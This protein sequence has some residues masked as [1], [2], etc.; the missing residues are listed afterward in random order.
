M[1]NT[2]APQ[3]PQPGQYRPEGN[4]RAFNSDFR[5]GHLN[6]SPEEIRTELTTERQAL[7]LLGQVTDVNADGN[8]RIATTRGDVDVQL[9]SDD[10]SGQRVQVGE[11]V[12]IDIQPTQGREAPQVTIRPAP[13]E[14]QVTRVSETPVQ[15]EVRDAQTAQQ[16]AQSPNTQI[17]RPEQIDSSAA[18]PPN[19]FPEVGSLV[20]LDPVSPEQLEQLVQTRQLAVIETVSNALRPL[21]ALDVLPAQ[22]V[23]PSA[24]PITAALEPPPPT[25]QTTINTLPIVSQQSAQKNTQQISLQPIF[26]TLNAVSASG[27]ALISVPVLS[28]AQAAVAQ[29]QNSAAL[30]TPTT[31]LETQQ[32]ASLPQD[33]RIGSIQPPQIILSAPNAPDTPIPNSVSNPFTGPQKAA[34]TTGT[35]IAKTNSQVP[36]V[37][38]TAPQSIGEPLVLNSP[39]SPAS[40]QLF[41]FQF[42]SDALVIGSQ[43]T[44]T[45]QSSMSTPA[46]FAHALPVLPYANIVFP[47]PWPVMQTL[48]QSLLQISTQ[49]AAQSAQAFNATIPS[50]A[51]SAQFGAAALFFVAAARG[52]DLGSWLGDKASDILRQSGKGDLL[53]RL[54]GEGSLLSRMDAPQGSMSGEWRGMNIPLMWQGDIHKIALHYKHDGAGDDDNTPE[55]NTGTRFIFDLNLDV[56]GKVQLDGFFRPVSMDGPRLDIVL[57]TEERFS[58]AMQAEMRRLYMDAIKPSQV[59]GELSFQDGLDAWVMIDAQD[60]GALGVN[61]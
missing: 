59:G 13:A 38:I 56:M 15:V 44:V 53:S 41:S 40:Q 61:A 42:P 58:G 37:Q 25:S 11:R 57:R 19:R 30:S 33:A 55:S 9:S 32:P 27:D 52:G 22:T 28:R 23:T 5:V 46:S 60:A 17:V 43:I 8:V 20:R 51:N 50:P 18:P 48:Q 54:S 6:A 45:P 16:Q 24:T 2:G 39:A 35:V 12:E 14:V 1:S 4:Q 47:Q 31:A 3:F 29:L 26:Q 7:R 49:A 21:P 36:I 10:N 34:Q